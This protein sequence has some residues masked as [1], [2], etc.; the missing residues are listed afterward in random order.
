[1]GS[2]TASAG[3][4]GSYTMTA[5]GTWT[6]ILNNNS[7]AVQALTGSQSLADSFTV[8]TI[9]GTTQVVNVTIHGTNDAAIISGTSTGSVV[10]AGGV[11]NATPG[12]PTATGT[13]TD[14]D[15]D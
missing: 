15:Y 9:D 14:V 10:E 7:S 6:Y 3:G 11:A 12:T 1:I 4:Y 5:D 13:S 8:R 2:P